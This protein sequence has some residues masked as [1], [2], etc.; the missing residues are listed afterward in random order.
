MS[1]QGNEHKSSKDALAAILGS[2]GTHDDRA[3][4]DLAATGLEAGDEHGEFDDHDGEGAEDEAF[5]DLSSDGAEDA[6]ELVDDL[7]EPG[8]AST[9]RRR[10]RGQPKPPTPGGRWTRTFGLLCLLGGT[11]TSFLE[12]QAKLPE[13]LSS[14]GYD[15]SVLLAV[16]T[17]AYV[18]GAMRRQAT[19]AQARYDAISF[20]Q[21]EAQLD[22]Q[23]N[24]QYLIE[25][26]QQH[27]ERPPAQG[28]ELERVLVGLQR[29]DEKVNNLSRALKMYGKPLMEIANQSADVSAQVNQVKGHLEAMLAAMQQGFTRVET[30]ARSH[31]IDIGP[32]AQKADETA[33]DLHR[34]LTAFGDRLPKAGQ[35]EQQMVRIEAQVQAMSQRFDDSDMR[36]SLVRLEDTSKV[37]GK[38]LE[39]LARAESL[40]AE[41]RKL[42][43]LLDTSIGKVGIA[44]DQVRD[45]NL[46]ALENAVRDIQRE[47]AGLATSVAYIQQ[48][49]RDGGGRSASPRAS[50]A[51]APTAAPTAATAAATTAP[52]T[53]PAPAPAPTAGGAPAAPAAAAG[54]DG[55]DPGYRTGK[56]ASSGKNVL[57]AIAKLKQM[58]S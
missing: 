17:V 44:V 26:Q 27:A 13:W 42:E 39:E 50:H 5:D 12:G 21:Q 51:P 32:L 20:Q 57:G 16:G 24:L 28:E 34:T 45:K 9:R 29:Q 8:R 15:S 6:L 4:G 35:I 38:K 31:T 1:T 37:H 36:K 22:M 52:T 47:L 19:L 58:K 25:Q 48:A 43:K 30:A 18:L 53:A 56:R 7:A 55:D 54:K 10:N 46:G 23:A 33:E 14:W 40:Q 2:R 11:F 41:S 3:D 49:V